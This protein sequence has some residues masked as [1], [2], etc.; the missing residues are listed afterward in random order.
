MSTFVSKLG[1]LAIVTS[2]G[3]ICSNAQAATFTHTD[4][5]NIDLDSNGALIAS[6]GTVT[7]TTNSKADTLRYSFRLTNGAKLTQ[8]FMDAGAG[9]VAPRDLGPVTNSLGTFTDSFIAHGKSF[10]ITFRH[11]DVANFS[12]GLNANI[13]AGVL[14]TK[15]LFGD[16]DP[17]LPTTPTVPGPVVG[18]GLPGLI[19]AGGGLLAWWRRKRT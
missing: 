10:S 14:T 16:G 12:A 18:A 6:V 9:G 2:L 19:F 15:G 8:V 5:Y 17:P 13:Y 11:T 3:V 4:I 1:L 7:I